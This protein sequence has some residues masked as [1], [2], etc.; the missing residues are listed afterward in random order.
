MLIRNV[1]ENKNSHSWNSSN[2]KTLMQRTQMANS[3][4]AKSLQLKKFSLPTLMEEMKPVEISDCQDYDA[5]EKN[6]DALTENSSTGAVFPIVIF[7]E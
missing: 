5:K 1:A 4:T 7:I 6:N 2:I 3:P